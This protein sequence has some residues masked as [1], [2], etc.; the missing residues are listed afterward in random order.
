MPAFPDSPEQ[1]RLATLLC[2]TARSGVPRAADRDLVRRQ[3]FY[4]FETA[5]RK[6]RVDMSVSTWILVG[7]ALWLVGATP[8]ALL[9]GR[10][11]RARD[12]QVPRD[13]VPARSESAI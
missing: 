10:V 9:L 5:Q 3:D 1:V 11:I 12:E 2:P 8:V 4:D 7:G 6:E 13:A